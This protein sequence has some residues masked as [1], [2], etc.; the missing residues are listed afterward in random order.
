[1]K[2]SHNWLKEYI[3]VRLKPAQLAERLSML[4]LEVAG[5]EDQAAQYEKFVI[6]VVLEA[7]KHPNADRLLSVRS[8]SVQR[9]SILSAARQTSRPGKKLSLRLSERP[10]PVIS[11]IPKGNLSYWNAHQY[12]ACDRMV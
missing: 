7:A 4:G 3:D 10:S 6:G 2:I 9:L 8:M 5:Y 12:A 11:M 1:M